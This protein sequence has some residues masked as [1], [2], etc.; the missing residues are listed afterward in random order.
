[1]DDYNLHCKFDIELHRDK[2]PGYTEVI[3][4]PDGEIEYAVPS[5]QEKLILLCVETL[6]I[7]RSELHDMCPREFWAD[8]GQWLCNM[9]KA[10]AVW[11]N[12]VMIPAEGLTVAQQTALK[13]LKDNHCYVGEVPKNV[14]SDI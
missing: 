12:F 6:C 3:I 8:F 10:V 1:M 5:H 14:R 13:L 11:Y 7:T 9:S 2:Y 4:R